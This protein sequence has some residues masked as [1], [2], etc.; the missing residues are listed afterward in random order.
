MSDKNLEWWI[1]IKFYVKLGKSASGML[2][3]LTLK[4]GEYALKK[5][6]I[7]EWHR[8]FK[9]GQEDVEHDSRS[10]QPKTQ[11]TDA[12]VDRVQNLVLSVQ[13]LGVRLMIGEDFGNLC[14]E[15]DLTGLTSGFSTVVMLLCMMHEGGPSEN[16]GCVARAQ[17]I[18]TTVLFMFD[19]S[20]H[21]ETKFCI[22]W[23]AKAEL[24]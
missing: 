3:L 23:L 18:P 10:G 7:F 9:E 21:A 2:T 4:Y 16:S 5:T 17:T 12:N 11:R 13:R 8:W 20:N 14:R 24:C 1:N 6:R 15:K 22:L 19:G